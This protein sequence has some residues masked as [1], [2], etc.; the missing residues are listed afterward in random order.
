MHLSKC[1]YHA[2]Q[3]TPLPLLTLRTTLCTIACLQSHKLWQIICSSVWNLHHLNRLSCAAA[4]WIQAR[5]ST[6]CMEQFGSKTAPSQSTSLGMWCMR[7]MTKVPF[8]LTSLQAISSRWVLSLSEIWWLAMLVPA[9]MTAS[10]S[11]CLH[12]PS[13][14]VHRVT[15]WSMSSRRWPARAALTHRWSLATRSVP[16]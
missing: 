2:P 10:S 14:L 4:W 12:L 6:T 1:W 5:C 9:L 13:P 16:R 3:C 7:R 8:W 11:V 15:W